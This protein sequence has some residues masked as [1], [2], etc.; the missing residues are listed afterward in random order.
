MK[1]QRNPILARNI[2][3]HVEIAPDHE[4]V[5]ELYVAV[6]ETIRVQVLESLAE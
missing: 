3:F 6:R 4:C 2:L 1:K 5:I